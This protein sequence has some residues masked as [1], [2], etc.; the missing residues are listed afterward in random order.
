MI[1]LHKWSN[2]GEAKESYKYVVQHKVCQKCG[3]IKW[4]KID[5]SICVG[6]ASVVNEGVA[7]CKA[8]VGD[9]KN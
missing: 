8:E 4:R 1:C 5:V 7:S 2:W 9:E 3:I 6:R